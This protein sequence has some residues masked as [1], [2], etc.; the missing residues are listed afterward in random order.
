[1]E[2]YSNPFIH[3]DSLGDLVD[4]IS[5]LLGCPVTV[6]DVNFRL[7]A[8]S[9]HAKVT[10]AAR[11]ATIINRQVPEDLINSLWREGVIHQLKNSDNPIHV[12][13]IDDAGFGS[14]IAIAVRN[15]K[16]LLGHIWVIGSENRDEKWQTELLKQAAEAVS[17]KLLQ[18]QTQRKKEQEGFQEFFRQI[19]SGQFDSQDRIKEKALQLKI[20]LPTEFSVIVFETAEEISDGLYR[21]IGYLVNTSKSVRV[22]MSMTEG[23]R[24][25]FL[26]DPNS[27]QSA[28]NKNCGTFISTAISQ[29]TEKLGLL[30]TIGGSGSVY[31]NYRKIQN[32]YQEA[33]TVLSI[34]KKLP[35]ETSNIF[36]YLQLGFFRFIPTILEKNFDEGYQNKALQ[37]IREYDQQGNSNLLETLE[38]FLR[39]DNIKETASALH[40]HINTLNYRLKRITEI[41]EIDLMDPIQKLILYFDLK[42]E[43]FSKE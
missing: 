27:R 14:R 25:I 1:M 42:T 29:I 39:N 18:N 2:K 40:I 5:D 32:S 38:I 26:V 34:K 23:N 30:K 12:F 31:S 17:V 3:I 21:Q 20:T 33:L 11:I 10:D 28:P 41:G 15:G 7:L 19:L 4:T 35:E 6:E 13:P 43:K 24:L 8:Y 37:K 36:L 16:D 9:S 22:I